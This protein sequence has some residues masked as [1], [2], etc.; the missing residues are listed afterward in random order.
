MLSDPAEG[1][2]A[3]AVGRIHGEEPAGPNA[4]PQNMASL[5][6][7]G[8]EIPLVVLPML[9]PLGYWRNWRYFDDRGDGRVGHRVGNATHYLPSITDPACPRA[10]FPSSAAAAEVTRFVLQTAGSH[11]LLLVFA[12]SQG[13][14][15]VLPRDDH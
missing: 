13:R 9:N 4:I 8:Q 2:G 10:A 5:G 7:L 1:R 15:D 14:A 6:Q 3:V 12:P 11:T